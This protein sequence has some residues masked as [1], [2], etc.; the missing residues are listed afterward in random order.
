MKRKESLCVWGW[1]KLFYSVSCIGL[2]VSICLIDVSHGLVLLF[3]LVSSLGLQLGLSVLVKLEL[4]DDKGRSRDANRNTG[5]V[6]LFSGDAL[7]V[8]NPLL[9]VYGGDLSFTRLVH[10]SCDEDLVV[11]ADRHRSDSV[12]GL[13]FL[14][15]VGAHKLSSGL[16]VGSEV[17]L[18]AL[19]AA[20]GDVGVELH[21]IFCILE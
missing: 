21:C 3:T 6:D 7:D 15:K 19:A 2:F 18:A 8:D 13:E 5:S 9:S 14:G 1:N 17:G 4:G 10:S 20:G 12:S 11:L 16:T